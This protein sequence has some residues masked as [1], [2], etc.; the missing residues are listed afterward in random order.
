MRSETKM[1]TSST[2]TLRDVPCC[3]RCLSPDTV[4]FWEKDPEPD[5][6]MT[7]IMKR[8]YPDARRCIDCEAVWW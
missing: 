1:T 6:V 3:P 4:G 2:P 8:Y 7:V 5:A